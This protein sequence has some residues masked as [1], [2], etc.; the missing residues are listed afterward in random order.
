MSR[1]ALHITLFYFCVALVAASPAVVNPPVL[2]WQRGSEGT[3]FQ[4]WSFGTN[5]A[6]PPPD[7]SFNPYADGNNPVLLHVDTDHGWFPSIDLG[8]GVWAL[9]GEIDIVIPNSPQQNPYKQI[10][11][12]LVWKPEQNEPT[13]APFDKDPF[14]PDAPLVAVTPFLDMEM[15]LN[16]VLDPNGW[17]HSAYEITIWP[18]PTKEWFTI[19]GNILVDGLSVDT[20]CVPEPATIAFLTAGG[21]YALLLRRRKN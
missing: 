9:S 5:N 12:A 21:L 13:G 4:E 20:I 19:K 18:N 17:Y 6:T 7:D 3:T 14:L 1:R 2:S 15:T 10:L 8:Q 16:N 11:L